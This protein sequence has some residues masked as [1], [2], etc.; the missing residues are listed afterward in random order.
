M[1][2]IQYDGHVHTPFCPHGSNASLEQYIEQAISL[3]YKG[4]SFCEHAPLPEGFPDPTPN[5]DSGMLHSHMEGYIAAIQ[6]VRERYKKDIAIQIGLEIDFIEGFET[7]TKAFLD[8]YGP[9]LDDAILSVHFIFTRGAYG[10]LDYSAEAFGEIAK[11]AGGVDQLVERYYETV[12]LSISSDLGKYKPHRLGHVSLVRKFRKNFKLPKD[13][14][15]LET[16]LA[17]TKKSGLS[18]DV[19]GAGVIKPL[20]GEPYPPV[21]IVEKAER[22]GI[23][24][25]YGSDAHHPDGLGQGRVGLPEVAFDAPGKHLRN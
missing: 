4:I 15:W 5:K 23:P 24:L 8:E 14:Y 6:K 18:L 7:G 20:C 2:K 13:A 3:G 22:M 21:A 19:N 16:V 25:V 10:L 9:H 1:K 17:A 11:Q 12:L